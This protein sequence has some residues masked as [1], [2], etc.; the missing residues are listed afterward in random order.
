MNICIN[1]IFIEG[2]YIIEQLYAKIVL[3]FN[4]DIYYCGKC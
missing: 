4:I 2:L 1:R 3:I